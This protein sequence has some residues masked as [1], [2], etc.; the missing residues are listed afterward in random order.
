MNIRKRDTYCCQFILLFIIPNI[1][2]AQQCISRFLSAQYKAANWY[3][4][5]RAVSTPGKE[6]IAIG[7]TRNDHG[8]ITRLSAKGSVLF[9][10]QY[11]PIY[12][13]NTTYYKDLL[14]NDVITA[15]DGTQVIAGTVIQDKYIYQ[16][17]YINDL[18][19]LFKVDKFGRVLWS[20]KFESLNGV[21]NNG[22]N[23][24]ISNVIER[25]NGDLLVFLSSD[26]G[27]NY[28]SY[29][30]LVCL[31]QDGQLKW[32]FLLANGYDG[33]LIDNRSIIETK[34][35]NLILAEILYKRNHL[36]Q[37]NPLTATYLH[38]ISIN[39][40]GII[41][42]ENGFVLPASAE[43][44]SLQNIQQLENG[45]IILAC[46]ITI[47]GIAD[48]LALKRAVRIEFNSKG[49]L[50]RTLSYNISSENTT[51]VDVKPLPGSEQ[52]YLLKNDDKAALAGIH[53]DGSIAWQQGLV[54]PVNNFPATCFT[55]LGGGYAVF[56]SNFQSLYTRIMLTAEQGSITCGNIPVLL[57]IDSIRLESQSINTNPKEQDP[58]RFAISDFPIK[59]G[60][61]DLT[62]SIDCQENIS[63]C[64]NTVDSSLY[65]I[66]ICEGEHYTLHDGTVVST[67][68]VFYENHQL[69]EGCDSIIYYNLVVTKNP[70]HLSLGEDECLK[71]KDSLILAATEGYDVYRWMNQSPSTD[72]LFKITRP[73]NYSVSVQNSCGEKSDTITVFEDCNLPILMPNAF[74]PGNDG[75]NDVFR[76]PPLNKNRFVSLQIFNRWGQLV[77]NSTDVNKGWDGKFHDQPLPAGVFIYFLQL[78]GLSGDRMQ[79]KGTIL[80]LR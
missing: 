71:G 58:N 37:G 53:P 36:L 73:G 25:N 75:R 49:S 56:M 55:T 80:L 42:W 43:P 32:S 10:R 59:D 46:N 8:F 60:A 33:S 44:P 78:R 15:S 1:C 50:L 69:P 9:S 11:N 4:P 54:D 39:E 3:I 18:G 77:F 2:L 21:N 24:G 79:Q 14:L 76:L 65:T 35:H 12:Q 74:S 57:S 7:N 72:S 17:E 26:Y 52:V 41:N 31:S 63:C 29:G 70:S 66:R 47:N 16:A 30:K 38:T 19:V 45:N 64:H 68:G 28:N 20:K 48:A 62:P 22:F 67:P 5:V 61:F 23:V 40:Q 27:K 6:I 13:N 51:V 34:D